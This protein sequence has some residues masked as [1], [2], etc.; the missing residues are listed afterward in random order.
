MVECPFVLG[1][2]HGPP[3]DPRR[4]PSPSEARRELPAEIPSTE[5]GARGGQ[6]LFSVL[7]RQ[8][9]YLLFPKIPKR[10][11]ESPKFQIIRLRVGGSQDEQSPEL[12]SREA[13]VPEPFSFLKPRTRLIENSVP[14]PFLF[15]KPW[16]KLAENSNDG[17][18]LTPPEV[19]LL[20]H[21]L[22][23]VPKVALVNYMSGQGEG[24]APNQSQEV[25][26]LREDATLKEE[27]KALKDLFGSCPKNLRPC[28]PTDLANLDIGKC[29]AESGRNR[30]RPRWD[31]APRRCQPH[32]GQNDL[33]EDGK[34]LHRLQDRLLKIEGQTRVYGTS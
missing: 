8:T 7:S 32:R 28:E 23:E 31:A 15:C 16:P 30:V 29:A 20:P 19:S 34:I 13:L 33:P 3:I 1:S 11:E 4:V 26:E 12:Q 18:L 25:A 14:E 6:Y 22:A 9:W 24:I 2:N 17:S 10:G 5:G 21:I 27:V